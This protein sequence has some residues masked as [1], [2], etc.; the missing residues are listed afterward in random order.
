MD[1]KT[2][3]EILDNHQKWR[4]GDIETPQKPSIITQSID[5]ILQH[6]KKDL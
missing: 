1:L 5:T 6:F 2:A 3:I 4:L